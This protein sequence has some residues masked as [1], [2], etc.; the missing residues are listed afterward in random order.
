V[1]YALS[2]RRT[3]GRFTDQYLNSCSKPREWKSLSFGLCLFHAVIQVRE[4]ERR[5]T[6]RCKAHRA[7]AGKKAKGEKS[8]QGSHNWEMGQG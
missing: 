6:H 2:F 8:K 4:Q 3:Y 5:T 7:M 1:L